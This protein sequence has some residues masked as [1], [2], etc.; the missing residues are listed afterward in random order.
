MQYSRGE[1]S[2]TC[3]TLH[4]YTRVHSKY[5]LQRQYHP[6]VGSPFMLNQSINQSR[7]IAAHWC[8]LL[9]CIQKVSIGPVLPVCRNSLTVIHDLHTSTYHST[10]QYIHTS[11]R[12]INRD[13]FMYVVSFFSIV[14]TR[15]PCMSTNFIRHGS[16]ST[17]P[18]GA[19]R[20]S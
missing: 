19:P 9:F 7:S 17:M 1:L 2:A 13:A 8:T 10:Y 12:G 11:E 16:H 14:Q 3:L 4:T 20:K 18:F 15:F 5:H 6:K